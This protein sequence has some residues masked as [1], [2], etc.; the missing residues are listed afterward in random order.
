MALGIYDPDI[1][2]TAAMEEGGWLGAEPD[3]PESGIAESFDAD[4][5]IVG[6][7][8]AGV[9]AARRATELGATVFLFEKCREPQARSGDFAAMNSKTA[10]TWGRND[11]DLK[12]VVATLM[13][14]MCYRPSMPLL[15]NWASNAGPVFD[16]FVEALPDLYVAGST[17]EVIPEGTRC[18]IQPRRFPAPRGFDLDSE[19]YPSFETTVWIRPSYL[20][21]FDANYALAQRSG[22]M[23]ARFNCPVQKLLRDETGRVTGAI[24]RSAEGKYIKAT[25]TMGVILSTGDYSSDDA[26]L[27]HYCPW[28]KGVNRVWTSFDAEKKPSN[29]GDG[30]RMG[31]W[32]GALMQQALHAPMTHHMGGP[33]GNAPFLHLNLRGK[34][35]MNEDVPGQQLHNQIEIQ[36]GKTSW[37]IYDSE[38]KKYVPFNSSNHASGCYYFE[39]EEMDSG[40]LY[41]GLNKYDCYCSDQLLEQAVA[42]GGAVKADT[43][44]ELLDKIAIPREA[45]LESIKRYNKMVFKGRDEDFGKTPKRLSPIDKGPFYAT[46]FEPAFMLVC[47]GGLESD[48]DARC[49]DTDRTPI[50]GLYVAG[51]VQGNRFSIEYPTTVCGISH[52]MALTF[53]YI[54]AETAV[55]DARL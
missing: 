48:E 6:G 16:W 50:P 47:M 45:A 41:K 18:W 14:D 20:P 53:G 40:K 51:N 21:V 52:S 29:T 4:I 28:V 49:L 1:L 31:L 27:Y 25:G 19:Y 15:E 8:L 35:F 43:L 37:Q 12:R 10:A 32:A 11:L 13:K 42:E 23:T 54:A 5:V 33:M 44:E 30:H 55:R 38:W 34:R 17:A 2:D 39:Q 24:G 46:K 26:M 7:G 3:I 22:R 9:A 36:P